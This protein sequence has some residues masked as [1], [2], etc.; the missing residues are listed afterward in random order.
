MSIVIIGS[1]NLDRY[2]LVDHF[3]RPGETITAR[4][5][6]SRFGGKGANQAVAAAR[7]GGQV[8]LIGALGDDDAGRA[9]RQRLT[10]EGIA[11]QGLIEKTGC[12][13]GSASITVDSAGE[14][15][16]IVD[17]GANSRLMPADLYAQSNL[18]SSAKVM[19]LQLEI[20]LETVLAALRLAHDLGVTVMLN[21]SPWPGNFPWNEIAVHTV[22]VNENE[23]QAWLGQPRFPR[24]ISLQRLVI[25]QGSRPTLGFSAAEEFAL[26]PR[27]LTPVDTVGAGDAFAGALAVALVEGQLFPD[28]VHFANTAGGLAT[29]SVGAQESLP[30]R[31]TLDEQNDRN[32]TA[33]CS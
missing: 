2:A 29:R 13:T 21:P 24:E 5:A 27:P 4:K 11:G 23:A 26:A 25:T 3:P 18:I 14:N 10:V 33:A 20:P 31:K 22:L 30:T 1:L 17:P 7:L 16:I 32:A 12:S 15:C 9:Y 19:V 28:A 8:A 6:F